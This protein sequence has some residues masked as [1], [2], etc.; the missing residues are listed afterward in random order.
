MSLRHPVHPTWI[1]TLCVRTLY[2][3]SVISVF[4]VYLLCD[5]CA[6]GHYIRLSV[7]CVSLCVCCVILCVCTLHPTVYHM[8][9]CCVFAV[10]LH[11]LLAVCW[12]TTS[13]VDACVF[14]VFRLCVCCVSAH[15]RVA[16]TH[17]IPYLYRSFSE[18]VTSI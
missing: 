12:H 1:C 6:F 14:A 3:T 11:S 17:R 18:K 16:K 8:C 9:V 7:T 2:S 4:A 5:C 13:E 10:N 15:Y